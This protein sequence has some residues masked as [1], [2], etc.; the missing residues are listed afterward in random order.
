MFCS[1]DTFIYRLC[2]AC[3][4]L[5]IQD[6]PADLSRHYPSNYYSFQLKPVPQAGI[7]AWIAG[8]RDRLALTGRTRKLAGVIPWFARRPD[9]ASLGRLPLRL[10]GRV[11]DI[12]CGQGE[13]L[14][15]LWR[16]GFYNVCGV[17]PYLPAEIE[18][19]PGVKVC[20]VP[21]ERVGGSYDLIM[22]H[23][24]LEHMEHGM[25]TLLACAARL[26]PGGHVLV[27]MPTV[28]SE[29]WETYREAWVQLDAPR[30]LFLHSR[31]SLELLAAQAG[32]RVVDWWCD[33]DGF[34][35][36]GSE[37]CGM[38][39]P[40][41]KADGTATLAQEHFTEQQLRE[42]KRR[43][44]HLNAAGRGDQIVAVL[45]RAPS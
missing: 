35:F 16:A 14:S 15:I 36:W 37:L 45:V 23:H 21:V 19:V 11:L 42:F 13:L 12:G 5:Q 26:V 18:V 2:S 20:N 1:G 27:R 3:G 32:L 30:H 29:A 25:E 33:S 24:V 17:D 7:R 44:R 41:V 9:V 4:C 28:D 34:Q 40:L 8:R 22:M 38:G 43:S 10:G 6:V 39:I 31:R